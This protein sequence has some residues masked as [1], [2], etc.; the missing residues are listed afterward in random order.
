MAGE[1][2]IRVWA[3]EDNAASKHTFFRPFGLTG[4]TSINSSL[5]HVVDSVRKEKERLTAANELVSLSFF[6]FYTRMIPKK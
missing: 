1:K 5:Y 3:G 2:E 6:S 4:I